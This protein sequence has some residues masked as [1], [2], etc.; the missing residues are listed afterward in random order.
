MGF[1]KPKF[2]MFYLIP[3]QLIIP[4]C[5]FQM[6]EDQQ[7]PHCME[8]RGCWGPPPIFDLPPPPRPPWE[9]CDDDLNTRP[10]TSGLESQSRSDPMI[11]D[12]CDIHP[13]VID[14][15]FY[16]G[17]S[18]FTILIIVICSCILVGIVLGVAC[19]IYR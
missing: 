5:V 16:V 13:L 19:I 11:Q 3:D 18:L 6:M 8:D 15:N 10:L 9:H 2:M 4:Y 17:E 14:S 7:H 12:T 1:K